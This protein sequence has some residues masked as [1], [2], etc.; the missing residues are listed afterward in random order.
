MKDY[1]RYVACCIRCPFEVE[2]HPDNETGAQTAFKCH[3]KSQHRC[4]ESEAREESGKVFFGAE[5]VDTEHDPLTSVEV[6]Y[7]EQLP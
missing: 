6:R 3:L 7:S 1:T 4:G 5:A 2:F